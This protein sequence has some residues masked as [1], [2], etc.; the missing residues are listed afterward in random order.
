M[1]SISEIK[2]AYF[3][4]TKRKE[5]AIRFYIQK[6]RHFAKSMTIPVT[7]LYKNKITLFPPIFHEIFEVGI[8]I[9]KAWHFS[10]C[11]F[12]IQKFRHITK[13]KTICVRF[14]I[15]KSKHFALRNFH[16]IF[17]ISWG[18]R[19]FL[20]KTTIY[21]ALHIYIE[22]ILHFTLH[23]CIQKSLQFALNVYFF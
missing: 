10:L 17:E 21:F 2:L 12:L 16:G 5:I 15:Q 20:Y 8:Y 13:R 23:F 9:Q 7:F 11:E 3:I 6:A 1:T 14:Y 19:T 22:K 18:G 4:Y